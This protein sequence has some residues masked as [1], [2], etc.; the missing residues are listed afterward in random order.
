MHFDSNFEI[1]LSKAKNDKAVFKWT[2]HKSYLTKKFP[3]P[4]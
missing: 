1:T 3:W 4:I 2:F